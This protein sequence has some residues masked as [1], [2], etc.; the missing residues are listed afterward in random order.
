MLENT[1]SL[2]SS[3]Q[4]NLPLLGRRVLQGYHNGQYAP[5]D[6]IIPPEI[7]Q[8]I[9]LERLD[10]SGAQGTGY[11]LIGDIPAEIGNLIN[12]KYLNL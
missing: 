5:I 4:R 3:Y 11:G 10:L 12:L 2:S 9:N 1:Q 6:D 7:G 8:L